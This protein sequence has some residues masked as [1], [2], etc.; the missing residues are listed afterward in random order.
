MATVNAGARL[1]RLPTSGFHRRILGLI[2][3]GMFLDGFEIY[4]QGGVLAALTG[5][6]WSTPAQ[7]ANFISMTFAGMVIGAWFAGI[8]GDWYGRRFSY[9]INLLVFGLASLA[10]AAAPSMDWLIAARFVMGIG[11]GAEIVVGYVT[12]SEFM[13]PASRGRWGAGLA[14]CTNSAL[15]VSAVIGRAVIPTYGWRWMFVM[16][17]VGAL[18]V[19]YLRKRMPESPRWLES[20][21]RSDEA[22]QVLSAIEADVEKS[23][24]RKLPEVTSVADSLPVP[25]TGRLTD[26]FSR[27]ML[28]RTIT[29]SVILI[30][31]NTALY[32]FV[33]FLPSFMVRQGLTVASSLNYITLMSFGGPVGAAL[34]MVL[35]DKLG[36]KPCVVIFSLAAILFGAIYPQL[37]DP[38]LVTLTGFLLVT[39][40][41]VMVAIAW[42]MYVPELFPTSIRMRGA[43]FC[44]TLGRFMTILTPQITTLLFAM[45]GIVAVLAFV[46]S[47][48]LLQVIVVLVFG[49]ET[50]KMP[51]EALSEAMLVRNKAASVEPGLAAET[52]TSQV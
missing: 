22:E 37:S 11:L 19:W 4:L 21:G 8:A 18:V 43:G 42:G 40:I 30:T 33:A 41:Y 27:E 5:I 47:L 35:A 36:R 16:V 10:G 23:T 24:G 20:H 38:T 48:L 32:G 50:K 28:G 46:V 13:P 44:N 3:G 52:R 12:L 25:G 15:F 6:G 1:D 39:A 2:G 26:L 9:Q 34:G 51:L 29:G 31:L 45:A 14:V 17:G 7:N 49:I